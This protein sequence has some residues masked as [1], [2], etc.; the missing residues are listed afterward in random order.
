MQ[1]PDALHL[2]APRGV[3]RVHRGAGQRR[4]HRHRA[5]NVGR[6][7]GYCRCS[8]R[9]PRSWAAC[10]AGGRARAHA[11]PR[12]TRRAHGGGASGTPRRSSSSAPASPATSW[13]SR[14]GHAGRGAAPR[15]Q[16]RPPAPGRRHLPGPHADRRVE[17]LRGRARGARRRHGDR[18]GARPGCQGA[19]AHQQRAG[20]ADE[21]AAPCSSTSPSTRAAASRDPRPTTHADPHVH[22]W[23][24]RCS[25]A[26]PTCRAPCRAP[27]PTLSPT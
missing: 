5:E 26:S 18:C 17:R 8:P 13:R 7:T 16:H 14:A 4:R 23:H 15:P 27:R 3:A 12:R 2:P 20:L 22:R 25:T 9:C 21:A 10:P 11:R 1:R 6:R 24:T 19:E